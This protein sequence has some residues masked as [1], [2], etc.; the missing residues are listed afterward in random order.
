M[1]KIILLFAAFTLMLFINAQD[2]TLE[3]IL[4]SYYEV[5]GVEKMSE[6]KTMISTGKFMSQGMEF[7]FKMY[8]KRP[9]KLKIEVEF[10]G[11]KM[12][13]SFNGT[14]GWGIVPWQSPDPVDFNDL[15]IKQ[16]SQQADMDGMLVN[17]EDKGYTLEYIGT[18][19]MEGTECYA[20]KL[21]TK[22]GDEFTFYLD[23]DAFVIIG[24]K[25]K[26]L[27]EGNEM[28]SYTYMGNYKQIEGI[29]VAHS[30]ENKMNGMT[31]SNIVLEDVKFNVEVDDSIFL[32]PVKE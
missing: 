19:E 7:P 8:N 32:K 24:T 1:K 4:E 16:M 20:L 26:V 13:Q 10:Q 28:I 3:E 30:M 22:E 29:A 17:Y 2:I 9:L 5:A 27:M 6:V 21:L 18:E 31:V 15:E 14:S 11:Q 12:I 25:A 23:L